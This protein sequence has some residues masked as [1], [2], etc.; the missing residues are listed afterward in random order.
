MLNANLISNAKLLL[1]NEQKN[2]LK[3]HANSVELSSK[4]NEHFL[5]GVPM[6][7]MNDWGTFYLR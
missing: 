3:L 5:Y 7:W 6:H 1:E 4:T 2:Y